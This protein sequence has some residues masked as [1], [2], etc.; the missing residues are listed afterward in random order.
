MKPARKK[1]LILIAIM[2]VGAGIATGFALK[3]FN[4]NLMYFFPQQMW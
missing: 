1:R 2:V 4:E 3:S